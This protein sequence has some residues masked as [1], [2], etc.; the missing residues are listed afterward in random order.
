MLDISQTDT[1]ATIV[2]LTW[3]MWRNSSGWK[4]YLDIPESTFIFT[5]LR[6]S[7][8]LK[9]K[10]PSS[11]VKHKRFVQYDNNHW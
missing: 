3:I 4:P 8:F 11:Q 6:G 5:A 1:L 9:N 10:I 2:H 7:I